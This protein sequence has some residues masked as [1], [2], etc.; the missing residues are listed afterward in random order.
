MTHSRT[1]HPLSQE[2][3]TKPPK[4]QYIPRIPLGSIIKKQR[5]IEK[6]AKST[7][8]I[9]QASTRA[10]LY[11]K[12]TSKSKKLL[13]KMLDLSFR[14]NNGEVFPSQGWLSEETDCSL[15]TV[16][17]TLG[18]LSFCGIINK[19]QRGWRAVNPPI[20]LYKSKTCLYSIGSRLREDIKFITKNVSKTSSILKNLIKAIPALEG[21][22]LS[23]CVLTS[24]YLN[25]EYL[26][27]YFNY[28][29]SS[30]ITIFG[31]YNTD[32]S[33]IYKKNE[34]LRLESMPESTG[35]LC[36]N[37]PLNYYYEDSSYTDSNVKEKSEMVEEER[38]SGKLQRITQKS[39]EGI[40]DI[41]FLSSEHKFNKLSREDKATAR[42]YLIER[43]KRGTVL[44]YDEYLLY[45]HKEY[46]ICNPPEDA[47]S[48]TKMEINII[49]LFSEDDIQFVKRK[50]KRFSENK[51]SFEW[52]YNILKYRSKINMA[53]FKKTLRAKGLLHKHIFAI[54]LESAVERSDYRYRPFV[55][56]K[57]TT[58]KSNQEHTKQRDDMMEAADIKKL[59]SENGFYH[60]HIFK[61][62]DV[63]SGPQESQT[64]NYENQPKK[65]VTFNQKAI[66]LLGI[67]LIMGIGR[68][69][70]L[71]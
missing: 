8:D 36:P 44:A 15:R 14:Y 3:R 54:E 53:E 11:Y 16:N 35:E 66:D 32:I 34:D 55:P 30:E 26:N 31:Q 64:N 67:D 17:S 1:H 41:R 39:E 68:R 49:K 47:L 62:K 12:M 25:N 33:G 59:L 42:R 21:M 23:F 58:S 19:E 37:D 43:I 18:Y 4:I 2:K 38:N 20:N 63:P 10:S 22:I 65:E 40:G 50:L 5:V 71:V 7:R 52:I 61:R 6:N 24:I 69:A 56:P 27:D 29:R 28:K 51:N 70:K 60:E 46:L 57:R 13:N 45:I 9:R 48:L